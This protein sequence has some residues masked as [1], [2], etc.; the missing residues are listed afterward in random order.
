[1]LSITLEKRLE[2][3]E[4][5]WDE[6]ASERIEDYL[7]GLDDR[8]RP[9]MLSELIMIDLERRFRLGR[10]P[11]PFDDQLA[12]Y[13]CRYPQLF[14]DQTLAKKID[15][16]R[17][18]LMRRLL[19]PVSAQTSMGNTARTVL[20]GN[21]TSVVGFDLPC[22]FGEFS[23]LRM[24]GR[25]GMG[26]VYEAKQHSPSRIVAIKVL[27]SDISPNAEAVSRFEREMELIASINNPGV[28]PVLG[29]GR[30]QGR[31]FY[32]MPL[33]RRG[34]LRD[35]MQSG[36]LSIREATQILLHVTRSV[37]AVHAVQIVHRDLKPG[38][39]LFSE[40]GTSL[41]ADFGLSRH[42][43]H[44]RS[45]TRTGEIYGTPGYIAPE[46]ISGNNKQ[47]DEFVV[48]IY[49]LGAILYDMLC[50]R[51]PFRGASCWETL[52]QAISDSPV[53]PARLN[54]KVDKDLN[55]IC[56]KCLE[57]E[58]KSRYQTCSELASD[59]ENYLAGRPVVAKPQ[60][61]VAKAIRFAKRHPAKAGLIVSSL[62][63]LVIT[64]VAGFLLLKLS[65]QRH[66]IEIQ[67]LLRR[68]EAYVANLANAAQS[69]TDRSMGWRGA[70]LD[71]LQVA[72]DLQIPGQDSER[73]RT[74]VATTT[75][76]HDLEPVATL[77]EGMWCDA[78]S[79]DRSGQFL[80]LGQNK[81]IDGFKVLIFRT[82]DLNATPYRL[83]IDCKTENDQRRAANHAKPED[84]ASDQLFT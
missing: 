46:R 53:A 58:P 15:Q 76:F 35:R 65:D 68:N 11:E 48:D 80:A 44:S 83:W 64:L 84:G 6:L 67:N 32:T 70:A 33:Y 31:L 81:D 47:I 14:A 51:P 60:A 30:A 24:I 72:A 43:D 22:E 77:A 69:M 56:M 1:M 23:L 62:G 82:D 2:R 63:L 28:V 38:N 13:Q 5:S 8:E 12:V 45:I 20:G 74:M 55:A 52:S 18:E 26:V 3:F 75:V 49:S 54:P 59:L 79:F 73:L 16:H 78:I 17:H 9:E 19:V 66:E 41:I 39:I 27:N 71:A 42:I 34:T 36:S 25:G 40:D 37:S 4:S 57:L 21:A 50:G 10:C 29:S 61:Q 7:V